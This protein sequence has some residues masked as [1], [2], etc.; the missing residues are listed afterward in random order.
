MF[1]FN[2]LAAATS[3]A[4]RT[5]KPHAII[6]GDDELFWVVSLSTMER[7]LRQGYELA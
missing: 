2:S 7:L 5:I 4:N 1:K 6:L 3:F